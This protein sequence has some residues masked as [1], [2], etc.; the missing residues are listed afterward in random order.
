MVVVM[1]ESTGMFL[2]LGEICD[3][4][5]SVAAEL[6][7]GLATDGLGTI[8]GGVFNT[9]P[10]TSFSQ[11]VG[12]VGM[13]GVRSR[14]VVAVSGVI[15]L[16]FGLFPKMGAVVASI[17]QAGAGRRGLVHVRHGRG[18]R[19]QDPR[20]RRLHAAAQPADHRR[21]HRASGMIPL[22]SPTFFAQAPK[23]LGPI[24]HSG[25]TLTAICAVAAQRVLQRRRVGRG[26][27]QGSGGSRGDAGHDRV[28]DPHELKAPRRGASC[29]RARLAECHPALPVLPLLKNF[30]VSNTEGAIRIPPAVRWRFSTK[31]KSKGLYR[32]ISRNP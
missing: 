10:Y 32:R 30:A 12:L 1:V 15:L 27:H 29:P 21:Q 8:I 4:K 16:A 22:V 13:T 20:A 2:A 14:Y 28:A 6:G 11:N 9:F 24:T 7:R 3:R 25:I 5:A 17:P 31:S 18:D 19:H 23:W 26:R